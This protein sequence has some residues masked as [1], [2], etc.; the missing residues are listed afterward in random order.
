MNYS[1]ILVVA[2]PGEFDALRA[3]LAS[4]PGVEVHYEDPAASRFVC[5][6]EA[7]DAD[8]AAERFAAVRLLP[9]AADASLLE[10]R[11]EP[12]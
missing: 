11:D 8:A 9:G 2:M 5:T 12:D 1:A 7:A 6:I 4:Q 10:E 3:R